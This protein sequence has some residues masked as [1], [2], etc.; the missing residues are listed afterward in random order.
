MVVCYWWVVFEQKAVHSEP[1]IETLQFHNS[2]YS[3]LE[4]QKKLWIMENDPLGEMKGYWNKVVTYIMQIVAKKQ[5]SE[6]KEK[7]D[8]VLS[9]CG[10]HKLRQFVPEHEM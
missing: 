10:T 9:N 7:G 5:N 1:W 8:D 2:E 3:K 4:T 6:R